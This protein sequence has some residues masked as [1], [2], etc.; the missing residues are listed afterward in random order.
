[1]TSS[2]QL[3][4][5]SSRLAAL[6]DLSFFRLAGVEAISQDEDT[7]KTIATKPSNP[8]EHVA[9]K[10]DLRV[11]LQYVHQRLSRPLQVGAAKCS[12]GRIILHLLLG[13]RTRRYALHFRGIAR[14]FR[15]S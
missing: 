5:S 3:S 14:E 4:P 15:L 11:I 1:M 12:L 9:S 8:I 13:L 7:M 6:S 2:L 10:S